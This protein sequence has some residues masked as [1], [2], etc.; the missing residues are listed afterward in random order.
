MSTHSNYE[1]VLMN[2][3]ELLTFLHGIGANP[4]KW[5]S[6]YFLINENIV[7]KCM[8]LA[9][10]RA[11]EKVLEIGPGPGSITKHLLAA[12]ATVLAIEKDPLFAK[13]LERL[14]TSDGR[15]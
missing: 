1:K 14:Q 13:H 15:L 9:D 12:G 3:T 4:K 10:I 6:Q 8:T 11:G 7:A 5:L 2:K